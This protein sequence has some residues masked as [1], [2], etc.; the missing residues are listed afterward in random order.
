MDQYEEEDGLDE[1]DEEAEVSALRLEGFDSERDEGSMYAGA[2]AYDNTASE[3]PDPEEESFEDLAKL[4]EDGKGEGK[5]VCPN[6]SQ[7]SSCSLKCVAT[8][9]LP[10]RR[11]TKTSSNVTQTL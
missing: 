9:E 2:S 5:N 7:R 1:E 11:V 6:L 10:S 8:S 3:D 4:T